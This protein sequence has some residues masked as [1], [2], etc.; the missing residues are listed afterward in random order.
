MKIRYKLTIIA[1]LF[2]LIAVSSLVYLLL[3]SIETRMIDDQAEEFELQL[4]Q[5]ALYMDGFVEDAENDLN[6]L[7]TNDAF[8]AESNNYTKLLK[9]VEEGY[10]VSDSAEEQAVIKI[11]NN[12]IQVNHKMYYAYIGR[13]DGSF[14][15]N[16]ALV[17][18]DAPIEERFDY[19]PRTRP[20]YIESMASP[21]EFVLTEPYV[22]PQTGLYDVTVSKTLVR[23][24][25]YFGVIAIDLSIDEISQFLMEINYDKSSIIGITYENS[26]LIIEDNVVKNIPRDSK[27]GQALDR[28]KHVENLRY[29]FDL[30]DE[31][32]LVVK[33]DSTY[34]KISYFEVI[35]EQIIGDQLSKVT[36][37][38]LVH[39]V[40]GAMVLI[41]IVTTLLQHIIV[42]PLIKFNEATLQIA[43]TKNLSERIEMNRKDE[44]GT[45]ANSFNKMLDELQTYTNDMESL[46]Y[47]R[48]KEMGRLLVAIEQSPLSIIIMDKKGH[49]DFANQ[50]YIISTGLS[51]DNVIGTEAEIYSQFIQGEAEIKQTLDKGDVWEG[52]RFRKPDGMQAIVEHLYIA[53][54]KDKHGDTTNFICIVDDITLQKQI[55][56]DMKDQSTFLDK[57]IDE[58]SSI[59]NVKDLDHRYI[60][61]NK[62][63]SEF[64]GYSKESAI[65]KT[66]EELFGH[67]EYASDM[68]DDEVIQ[69]RNTVQKDHSVVIEGQEIFFVTEAFPIVDHKGCVTS[70]CSMSTDITELKE[71]QKVVEASEEKMKFTLSSIGAHYW[72]AYLDRDAVFQSQSFFEHY[73]YNYLDM[74]K[75]LGGFDLLIHPEDVEQAQFDKDEY[76][77][78]DAKIYESEFRFRNRDGTYVWLMN[79]GRVIEW[80]NGKPLKLVGLTLDISERKRDQFDLANKRSQLSILFNSMTVGVIMTNDEGIVVEKNKVAEQLIGLVEGDRLSSIFERGMKFIR[81]DGTEIFENQCPTE[82]IIIEGLKEVQDEIGI[83]SENNEVTWLDIKASGI[84]NALG[85]G[86]VTVIEDV[87]HKK[88][89][90]FELMLAKETAEEATRAKSDF[91]ANMSHEIRTPMN[92]IIGLGSLLEKTSLDMKQQDYATKINK[93]AKNLL[94]IINDVLDFSKIE[95]GKLDI[96]SVNFSLDEVLGNIS[97]VIG[98]KSY[99]KDIELILVK[100]YDVPDRL[101]GDSLRLNQVL[102]NLC[103]NAVKFTDE[104][105]VVLRVSVSKKTEDDV[106]LKFSIKDSGIGMK[107]EQLNKL[108]RAF[109]QAD[110]SITRKYG[111]TG[112]GLTISK[113]LVSMMGGEID[114]KSKF[115]E[116]SEFYFELPFKFIDD[117][118]DKNYLVPIAL[119]DLRIAV[120]DDNQITLEVYQNYLKFFNNQPDVFSDPDD[121]FELLEN[122]KYDLVIIDYKL[123]KTTGFDVWSKI[124]FE[125]Q[126]LPKSILA[127]AHW[128]DDVITLA[129]E[130][131]FDYVLAKP[132][133]QS[134]IVDAIVTVIVGENKSF[135][136]SRAEDMYE[137]MKP[138]NGNRIL[139]VE[140][141]LINQQ[142]AIENLE[143]VGF[144]VEVAN[145]GLEAVEMV[146]HS[147]E[148]F[149]LVLMDLQMPIMDG[150]SATKRIREIYDG[151]Q[152]P[153][154]ALS[155]DVMK[156]TLI[157]IKSLGAQTHV[158]KPLDLEKLFEAMKIILS[159]K[160]GGIEKEKKKKI[161]I[162]FGKLSNYIDTKQALERIGDNHELYLKLIKSFSSMYTTNVIN[163]LDNLD[164]DEEHIRYFHTLKGLA[165]NIGSKQVLELAKNLEAGLK[166]KVMTVESLPDNTF[167][168]DLDL[169]LTHLVERLN[170]FTE[171]VQES[172]ESAPV[173][174]LS[175]KLFNE[176]LDELF[177]LI[178]DY[179]LDSE[180]IL[181]ELRA[182]IVKVKGQLFYQEI[183]DALENYEYDEA[184]NLLETLTKEGNND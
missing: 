52:E 102:L 1:S 13:D 84:S 146:E 14:T 149:D 59:I 181:I 137:E 26:L 143:A 6:F 73:G 105:E 80:K 86:V 178:D 169:K 71:K 120:I 164:G 98:L 58:S 97:S 156:E 113:N 30:D 121:F 126:S 173:N 150:F 172:Q 168:K 70:I 163:H 100:E 20:W 153:I 65:G 118:I 77:L 9:M 4:N 12:Y 67:S 74:P 175:S 76:S 151:E 22:N 18:S 51:K 11:L 56:I 41:G 40:L 125:L 119:N 165:G 129:E 89:V 179:D 28:A 35:P 184:M 111:G 138:Y 127:T 147:A 92:A 17:A 38:Y 95:A 177:T 112:L 42:K 144:P 47:D 107:E 145:N 101:N 19:D 75:D 154:I 48:T 103:N 91:L 170:A 116:G 128:K 99:E 72:E 45:M 161:E 88:N 142:V 61:V 36:S 122:D 106:V 39:T 132:I 117:P 50:K 34:D 139:L 62:R 93:A 24:N 32:Y 43:E 174:Y 131:G 23:N 114:V 134:S 64:T 85:G 5:L 167:V 136:H 69:T 37:G 78:N 152:L 3:P 155:A 55:E 57:L 166:T 130:S 160:S 141:N 83:I 82:R 33:T 108:F 66:S 2:I 115:N 176:K 79:I 7:M 87:T 182:N 25:E 81:T 135:K 44:Y 162:D 96:E 133:T 60:L 110:T 49:I 63:W 53:P 10:V 159:E 180:K 124:M 15:V 8:F 29:K 140:D 68:I 158:A 21:D 46:I 27:L 148:P 90:E 16:E 104:G 183:R 157:R 171:T 54:T 94:G 123:Q 31:S 109:S